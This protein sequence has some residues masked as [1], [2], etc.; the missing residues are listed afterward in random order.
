MRPELVIGLLGMLLV[1]IIAVTGRKAAVSD[2][3]EWAV[4]GRSYGILKTWILQ[5]GE[6]FTT[7]TFLGT[8]GV[9]VAAGGAGF[10]AIPY[11]PLAYLVMYFM[12]PRLWRRAKTRGYLT[13]AD[14]IEDTY[15]SR[16]LGTVIGVVGVLILLPYIQL[17]IT[18]L[19]LIINTATGTDAG[20]LS[21][22]F[23]FVLVM[24]FVLY[25]GLGGIARVSFFKDFMM[26][27]I[28]V[29]LA[30]AIPLSTQH[31]FFGTIS[32]AADVAPE[33]LFAALP[34]YG[35]VWVI[36]SMAVSMVSVMFYAL[37]HIWPAVMASSG[38]KVV[39]RNLIFLPIY[40]LF[41]SVAMLL[42]YAFIVRHGM[43]ADGSNGAMLTMAGESLPGWL[44]GVVLVAGVATAMVPAAAM[45]LAIAPLVVNNVL[46]VQAEERKLGATRMVVVVIG[47]LALMLALAMP[48]L[49]ANMLL[50]TFSGSTQLVPA[51]AFGL[52]MKRPPNSSAILGGLLV[53]LLG[54]VIAEQWQVIVDTG[55]NS[56][57]VALPFNLL[58]LFLIQRAT[59]DRRAP[60][61]AVNGPAP[62]HRPAVVKRQ[63]A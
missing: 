22:V 50:L 62:V 27:L 41:A 54:V 59:G 55:I 29:M 46:R 33:S 52:L 58:A 23:G 16:M 20:T 49:L 13:Q 26:I 11:V 19:S 1:A 18:G 6:T 3:D 25:A 5:A 37:P 38:E 53:G 12:A 35:P 63:G 4:A 32:K 2:L 56:G 21:S 40:N 30:V 48:N 42:A 17:Q 7:F 51:I 61:P 9:F 28:M 24:V 43:A 36:S 57:L 15:G 60:N 31:G 47:I 8:V 10:Y 34:G 44:V 45:L 39:R 14:F